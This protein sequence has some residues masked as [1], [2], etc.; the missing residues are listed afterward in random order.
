MKKYRT[1]RVTEGIPMKIGDILIVKYPR[2][3]LLD[4]YRVVG[5]GEKH[6]EH[7]VTVVDFEAEV[8]RCGQVG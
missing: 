8:V 2:T 7:G 6:K 1:V 3:G 4:R 5:G